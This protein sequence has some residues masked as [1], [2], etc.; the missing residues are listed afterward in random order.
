M[1]SGKRKILDKAAYAKFID[2]QNYT[3]KKKK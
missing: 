1:P 3:G 2:K